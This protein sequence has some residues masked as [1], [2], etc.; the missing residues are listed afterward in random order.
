MVQLDQHEQNLL[1]LLQLLLPDREGVF[2][3]VGVNL[4]QTLLKVKAICETQ[5]YVGFEPNPACNAYVYELIQLNHL[6]SC[7][8]MPVGLDEQTKI[9]TL[10]IDNPTSA[11]ASTIDGFRPNSFYNATQ[12]VAVFN[13]DEI[14]SQQDIEKVSVI[15]IDV[16]GGELE[17]LQGLRQS[18]IESNPVILMEILPVIALGSVVPSPI[19]IST[20]NF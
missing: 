16:E 15:K 14:M 6:T 11:I 7:V 19:K 1:N 2:I 18:I 5:A 3:D 17:V 12:H 13:G 10:F 4:G 9:V 8:L 20:L